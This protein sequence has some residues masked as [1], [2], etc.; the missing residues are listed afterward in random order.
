MLFPVFDFARSCLKVSILLFLAVACSPRKV[1]PD[2]EPVTDFTYTVVAES[3][4][5]VQ[6]EA[7]AVGEV[8]TWEFG[9]KS[10]PVSTLNAAISHVYPKNGTYKVVMS[11][12]KEGKQFAKEQTIVVDNR[13]ARTFGDLPA[14]ER[15]TIRILCV[16]THESFKELFQERTAYEVVPYENDVFVRFLQ[17]TQPDRP[18][19]LDKLVFQKIVHVLSPQEMNRFNEG[20]DPA[21]F[22]NYLLDRPED[23]LH[24]RILQKKKSEAASRI[25]FFMK[26]PIINGYAKYG[27]GGY[28]V[29]EGGYFVLFSAGSYVHELG[30]SLGF[31]HDTRRNC[32]YF[33]LM[34]GSETQTIGSCNSLWL[35]RREFQVAGVTTNMVLLRSPNF[36]E[37]AVPF[38][39]RNDF[40]GHTLVGN[41]DITYSATT[42]YYREGVSLAQTVSDALIDQFNIRKK[43]GAV[44]Q[45][46]LNPDV[47]GTTSRRDRVP[48]P[49]VVK[50]FPSKHE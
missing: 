42:P 2:N 33:P 4:G 1:V 32:N 41:L 46:H 31:A 45:L 29:Y 24:Q 26:D 19:E 47:P 44:T 20:A 30:H 27:I 48:Q 7:D 21:Y 8:R 9:D 38:A 15:D 39:Y 50:C 6:F 40:P 49:K 10:T 17:R 37:H 18:K 34:G 43:P 25:A 16:V 35:E 12:Q 3:D 14:G 11:Y 5:L 23:P 13:L 36:Y 28:S 22:L